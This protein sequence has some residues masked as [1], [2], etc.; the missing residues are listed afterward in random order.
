MKHSKKARKQYLRKVKPICTRLTRSLEIAKTEQ[1]RR[2]ELR[3]QMGTRQRGRSSTR[4]AGKRI[5]QDPAQHGYVCKVCHEK[6]HWA[7]HC[8][9]LKK[10]TKLHEIET[11]ES[12][13]LQDE[14][15]VEEL[16]SQDMKNE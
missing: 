3:D 16:N 10:G 11:D 2:A 6:N 12:T 13:S 7:T 4:N 15:F 1:S 5:F 14:F 9:T 8:P